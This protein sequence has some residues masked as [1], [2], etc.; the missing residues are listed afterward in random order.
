[1]DEQEHPVMRALR[2]IRKIVINADHG[3]FGLSDQACRKYLELNQF[4]YEERVNEHDP[5]GT[6]SG[7]MFYVNDK[8]WSYRDID[9]DD[10]LLVRVVEELGAEANSRYAS[11]KIVE[12]PADV[13][14]TL[15]EY[16]GLE[17]IAEKHRT[18][19]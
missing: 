3:G 11:L 15:E 12:I 17:W 18:W 9:R 8:F 2:G 16:D 19:R 1:V 14:W 6:I 7:Q 13:D 5:R 10:P 4:S